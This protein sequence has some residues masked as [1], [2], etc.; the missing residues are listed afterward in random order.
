MKPSNFRTNRFLFNTKLD[1]FI[2]SYT[3][4]KSQNPDTPISIKRTSSGPRE[5]SSC[6][7]SNPKLAARRLRYQ[8]P[9]HLL[10]SNCNLRLARPSRP[11]PPLREKTPTGNFHLP[12]IAPVSNRQISE[13]LN[14][15]AT[16]C[17]KVSPVSTFPNLHTKIW[18]PDLPFRKPICVNRRNLRTP[19]SIAVFC[20][21]VTERNTL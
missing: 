18:K 9:I 11:P 16:F 8:R 19:I 5:S 4:I 12:K 7:C 2:I 15:H 14:R 6:S 1:S 10:S 3:P 13:I 20:R 21:A 17:E